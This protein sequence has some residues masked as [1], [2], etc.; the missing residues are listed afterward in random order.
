VAT[1]HVLKV[2]VFV[3]VCNL[4]V[5]RTDAAGSYHLIKT[6]KASGS[7]DTWDFQT[8]DQEGRRLYVSHLNDVIVIN[9]DTGEVVG[10]IPKTSGVHGVAVAPEFGR[11][12]IS[13]G[14][15][16][17]VVAFDLKTLAKI[18]DIKIG[19]NP[20]AI[21]YDPASKRVFSFNG[22]SGDATVIEASTGKVSGTIDIGG[23]PEAAAVDGVG[24]VYLDIVDK[25]LVLQINSRT[26]QV[27]HRWPTT[28]CDRPTSLDIDT[29]NFRL[30]IGCRNL[31][32][33]VYDSRDGH[34]VTNATIGDN[35]DTTAFDPATGFIFSSTGDGIVTII[36]E[37]T[38]DKYS[39]AEVLKSHDGSKTMAL[40]LKTHQ[41]FVPS[42]DVRFLPPEKTGGRPKKTIVPGTFAILVFGP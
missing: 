11:G 10:K 40:D 13:V 14:H 24:N 34:F 37:D 3:L 38:P 35:V 7:Q 2:V 26:M 23:K 1:R 31:M 17:S 16:D 30:F 42:G 4:A 27:Q 19:K 5:L 32:L 21:V 12:F 25:N 33:G 29:R 18:G 8:I 20:D 22:D 36:H 41:I 15:T 28:P 39:V 6:I 9:V